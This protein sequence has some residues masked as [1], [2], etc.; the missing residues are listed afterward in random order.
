MKKKMIA[1]GEALIDFIPGQTGRALKDVEH[2]APKIGG[3]PTNAA[4]AFARLGGHAALLTKVGNDPFGGKVVSELDAYGVDVSHVVR[5]D[6]A[7]TTLAFVSL[8]ADG[9]REFSFYRNPGAEMLYTADEVPEGVFA[10]AFCLH[11]TSVSLGDY[12]MKEAHTRAI[13][14]IK[15]AGGIV[16]FDPNV[17]LSLW[18]DGA[19]LRRRIL[20]FVPVAHIVKMSDE[21]LEFVTGKARIEDALPSL[22][23]GD[24]QLVLFTKGAAGAAAF[25][26]TAS[27]ECASKKVAAI[28]TTGAGDAFI[29][30]FLFKLAEMGVGIGA[31]GTLEGPAL[32][33]LLG[34][35]N[36]YCGYSVQRNGAIASYATM[37][38]F[39]HY[40]SSF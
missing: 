8:M 6:E 24:V 31:L 22:F 1:I 29:G 15:G 18:P 25:T 27:A 30:S 35:A 26:R 13:S 16:S 3:G 19:A 20:E 14:Y 39:K 5:T 34:F 2:F 7:N 11:F 4:G 38:E 9:Q 10:D 40:L 28:D 33:E 37:E 32:S 36:D 23:T 17:R 12:P 21:E